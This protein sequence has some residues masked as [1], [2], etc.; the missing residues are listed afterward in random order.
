MGDKVLIVAPQFVNNN[1]FRQNH[2]SKLEQQFEHLGFGQLNFD[3][4][5]NQAMTQ[6][7]KTHFEAS[8]EQQ[9]QKIS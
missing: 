9:L 3:I 8:R 6:D 7:L 1:H 4:V 5:S 2:L